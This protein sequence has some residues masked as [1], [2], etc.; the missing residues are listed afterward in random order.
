MKIHDGKTIKCPSKDCDYV[1]RAASEVRAHSVKHEEMSKYKCDFCDYQSSSK[2]NMKRHADTVHTSAD[3]GYQCSVCSYQSKTPYALKRHQQSHFGSRLFSCP[4]CDYTAKSIENLRTHVIHRTVHAGK[5]LYVCSL[6]IDSSFKTN[7]FAD[8]KSH[9][10]KGHPNPRNPG[11]V[12]SDTELYV[13]AGIRKVLVDSSEDLLTMAS[14]S[15]DHMDDSPLLPCLAGMEPDLI[16][17]SLPELPLPVKPS[18]VSKSEDLE[19]AS[20]WKNL[21]QEE[22]FDKLDASI[23]LNRVEYL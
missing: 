10:M 16:P 19:I 14:A 3:K 17:D 13:I 21:M 2:S 12:T 5:K 9:V 1:G 8:F 4:Y 23:I 18:P 7:V 15:P 20:I 6:C 11:A 22:V